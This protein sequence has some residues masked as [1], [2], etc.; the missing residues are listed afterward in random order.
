[1]PQH[2]IPTRR[3]ISQTLLAAL[4]LSALTACGFK[5]RGSQS[6]AFSSIAITPH[7]G[8]AIAKDLRRALGGAVQVVPPDAPLAQAQV[9]LNVAQEQRD[10]VVVGTNASGQVREFQLRLSVQFGLTT[11]A[12]KELLP[13]DRLALQR[14]F[15]YNE[16]YALAKETEEALLYRDM[17]TDIVQQ[18]LRRLA[19]VR[20]NP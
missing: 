18:I 11:P 8:G 20:L 4:S 14:D 17:Q 19:T 6:Y 1:M 13:S 12:G 2:S 5:L 16:S 7:P 10:K 9:V 3:C 15:S